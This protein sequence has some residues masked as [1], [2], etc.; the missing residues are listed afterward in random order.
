M[1]SPFSVV[2]YDANDVKGEFSLNNAK[3]I[4]E[5]EFVENIQR[6]L[7][8]WEA[9][10]I[11]FVP[12]DEEIRIQNWNEIIALYAMSVDVVSPEIDEDQMNLL[13]KI[14]N[15]T[16]IMEIQI[17]YGNDDDSV[18]EESTN[19]NGMVSK[20]I[21]SFA[22]KNLED[23]AIEYGMSEQECIVLKHVLEEIHKT[24]E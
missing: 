1:A 10:S 5:R 19:E 22:T 15:D 11:V 2:I 7:S 21:V 14:V 4:L 12:D 16:N 8:V 18:T 17:Q 20:I 23:V 3:E 13:R 9:D 24:T 6:E